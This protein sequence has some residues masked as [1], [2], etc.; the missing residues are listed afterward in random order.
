M[1]LMSAVL[2]GITGQQH[3]QR[4]SSQQAMHT[5]CICTRRLLVQAILIILTCACKFLLA[6]L[7]VPLFASLL[8]HLEP[9]MMPPA[10]D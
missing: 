5:C 9:F 7:T 1:M 4:M 3:H 2:P 10:S 8:L 6:D